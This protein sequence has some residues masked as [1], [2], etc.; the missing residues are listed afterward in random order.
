MV[1]DCM[2]NKTDMIVLVS[3]DS[4]LVPP[5]ELIQ[6]RFPSIPIK[7]YFPPSNFSNDLKDNLI[8]HRSK[9]VL[10][11]K[12]I[13]RFQLALMPEIVTKDGKSYTIPD[14]WKY[15]E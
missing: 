12:N 8:H 7:V 3:A 9:P 6:K 13:R 11:I 14:K 2:M 1:D 5:I 15:N 4:D 10:L